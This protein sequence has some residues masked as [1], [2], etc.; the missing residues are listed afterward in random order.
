MKIVLK[1]KPLAC[2][3][4]NRVIT[5]LCVSVAILIVSAV[6]IMVGASQKAVA[7][8]E[9]DGK[10]DVVTF[11]GTVKD[12][13]KEN[14]IQLNQKD[15]VSPFLKSA[16]K[17]GMKIV[18]KRAV[19]VKVFIDGKELQFL[20]AAETVEDLLISEGIKVSEKDKVYPD[21][22]TIVSGNLSVKIVRVTEKEITQKQNIAYVKEIK[23]MPEWERGVEKVL[24]NG[25]NGEKMTTIKITYEDGV[26]KKREIVGEK[27]NKP[28]LSNLIA[29]GTLDWRPA[30]RGETIKFNRVITMKATSYS[31]TI[32]C[33]GKVGGNTATGVKP[34]RYSDGSKWSTAAVDPNVIPLG[35][36]L[37]IEGYG[38]A[39]AEDVGGAVKGNIIDLFFDSS[40]SEYTKWRTHYVKVYILK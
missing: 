10:K 37:W 34:R 40:S 15:K 27:I 12:V 2:F 28:A 26:E 24:R 18:I 32:E 39:I 3:S 1:N 21:T 31:D 17:D 4:N 38:Y 8:Y 7:I 29:V 25:S 16:V 13:L 14:K 36:R 30:S 35:S 11:K 22:N 9:N 6:L 19:P 23:E 20:S 33:T 5:G